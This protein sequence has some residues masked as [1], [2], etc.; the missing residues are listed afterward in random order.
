MNKYRTNQ[1]S[2]IYARVLDY[3]YKYGSLISTVLTHIHTHQTQ[4]YKKCRVVNT[5]LLEN[6]F[7]VVESRFSVLLA[8]T[9]ILISSPVKSCNIWFLWQPYLI[10]RGKLL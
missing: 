9:E 7:S 4:S 6:W 5:S 3:S 10:V 1:E 2:H 8:F